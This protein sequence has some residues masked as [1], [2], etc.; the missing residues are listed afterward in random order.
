MS[1]DFQLD[2][3]TW[4]LNTKKEGTLRNARLI[5]SSLIVG[6]PGLSTHLPTAQNLNVCL[7]FLLTETNDLNSETRD[8]VNACINANASNK[9]AQELDPNRKSA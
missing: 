2:P 4:I 8:I 1:K 7:L 5:A 3:L 9:S 6:M